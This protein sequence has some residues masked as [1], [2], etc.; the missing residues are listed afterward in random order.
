[1]CRDLSER[2]VLVEPYRK[3]GK[4]IVMDLSEREGCVRT[5]DESLPRPRHS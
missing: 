3:R 1:M 4:L 2:V 5:Q